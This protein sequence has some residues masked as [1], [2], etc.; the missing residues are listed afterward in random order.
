[1]RQPVHPP[2]RPPTH[3]AR[4]GLPLPPQVFVLA[5]QLKFNDEAQRDAY[6][7]TWRPLAEYVQASEPRTLSFELS[8]ADNAPT[9]VLVF[10]R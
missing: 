2:T 8:I 10:E 6:I 1:M 3:P 7:A 4:C 9:T 5:V